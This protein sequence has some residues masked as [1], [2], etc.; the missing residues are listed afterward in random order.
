MPYFWH[1]DPSVKR[2]SGLLMPSFG[3][4]SHLG[5]FFAQPYYWVIDDQSDATF[6]PMMTTS[7]GPHSRPNTGAGSTAAPSRST[8]RV[9]YLDNSVQAAVFSKGQFNVDDTWRWGFYVGPRLVPDYIRDFHLGGRLGTDPNL[10]TSQLYAEGFGQG[11]YSRL[12]FRFYQSLND[13]IVSDKL[14][15]VLPRYQYSY[16]GQPDSLGGRLSIEAAPSMCVRTVGTN[17]RRANLTAELVPALRRRAGRPVEGHAAHRRDRLRRKQLQPAAEF[18]PKEPG[19]C[20]ARPAAG[21][22]RIPLAVH[23]R[24][25]RVGHPAHR[26]DRAARRRAAGGQQPGQQD[27]RTRTA[28]IWNSPTPTCS[29]STAIPG[30]IGWTAACGRTSR[31]T[32]PGIL[33]APRSTGCIGQSYRTSTDN[34]FPEAFRPARL[35]VGCRRA[36]QFR[37]DPLAEPDLSDPARPQVAADPDGGRSG[38]RR[39]AEVHRDRR[40]LLQHASTLTRCSISRR[41]RRSASPSSRRAM[42]SPSA[43]RRT[44]ATIGSA[45]GCDATSN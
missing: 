11:A 43:P 38:D 22:A 29:G 2:A 44:G 9:G 40:L 18:R 13:L 1:A 32:A 33:A 25:G 37:A 19:G 27:T 16:F 23:A 26:A 28:S 14:P 7:A 45:A 39:R 31:C 17:T 21:R 3:G 8:A 34:Q 35:G 36:R 6:T 24:F 20:G 15:L 5:A 12:D 41:R 30:S 42:R 4:S 10:L